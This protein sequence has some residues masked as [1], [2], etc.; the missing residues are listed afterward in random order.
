MDTVKLKF[1]RQYAMPSICCACGLPAGKDT[2]KVSGSGWGSRGWLT[3]LF[4]LCD[5]CAQ[6][7]APVA[8]RRKIGCGIGAGLAVLALVGMV[9]LIIPGLVQGD[10]SIPFYLLLAVFVLAPLGGL[11]A[12]VLIPG[13]FSPAQRESSRKIKASAQIKHLSVPGPF[14]KGSVTL[15]LAHQPFADLFRQMNG[16]L[17]IVEDGKAKRQ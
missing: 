16:Q 11:L 7:L 1:R 15:C 14:G 17:I 13:S 6:V 5:A 2:L 10:I 12:Y 3:L 9:L 8:R 4:P